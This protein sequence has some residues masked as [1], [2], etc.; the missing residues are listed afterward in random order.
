MREQFGGA[1]DKGK[2]LYTRYPSL[3]AIKGDAMYF[4]ASAVLADVPSPT[5]APGKRSPQPTKPQDLSR[6]AIQNLQRALTPPAPAPVPAEAQRMQATGL[7]VKRFDAS[8]LYASPPSS[9]P[10]PVMPATV[11]CSTSSSSASAASSVSSMPVCDW[12]P[13]TS[14]PGTPARPSAVPVVIA[15][16]PAP[17]PLPAPPPVAMQPPTVFAQALSSSPLH[18]QAPPVAVVPAVPQSQPQPPPAQAQPKATM[19][20]AAAL[21]AGAAPFVPKGAPQSSQPSPAL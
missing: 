18:A 13:V 1:D 11:A 19:S 6:V 8:A 2:A 10:A 4:P 14:P 17:A 7:Q 21:S 16:P 5:M 20:Y 3:D 15:S 9:P 12:A